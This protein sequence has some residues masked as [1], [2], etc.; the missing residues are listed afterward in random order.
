MRGLLRS[1]PAADSL[2]RSGNALGKEMQVCVVG[3]GGGV[4][5]G[6]VGWGG[7]GGG[8]VAVEGFRFVVVG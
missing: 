1:L 8:G 5:W 6:G 3:D 7:V 4:G 2:S